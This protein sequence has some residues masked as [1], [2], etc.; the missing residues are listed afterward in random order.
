M[1]RVLILRPDGIGDFIIFSGV[2]EEYSKL[3]GDYEIHLICHP[4]VRELA[5]TIPFIGKIICI[6]TEKVFTKRH[7]FYTLSSVMKSLVYRYEKA[8][9]P[10]Y[11]PNSES[12]F[13]MRVARSEEKVAYNGD[14]SNYNGSIAE[15]EKYYSYLVESQKGQKSEL[16][17][18]L[19]FINKLGG[20]GDLVCVKPKI[21][22]AE[23]DD[24]VFEKLSKKWNV[25]RKRYIAIFPGAGNKIK[26]WSAGKWVELISEMLNMGL[27]DN[28]VILGERNDWFIIERI[29]GSLNTVYRRKV[30]N[31]YNKTPLRILA[32]LIGNSRAL[33]ASDSGAI[34]IASALNVPNICIMGGGHFGRFYPYGDLTKNRAVYKKLDCFG[35]NWQCRYSEPKCIKEINVDDI[36]REIKSLVRC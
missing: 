32:K 18:N 16:E 6:A 26:C 23:G 29:I 35:C 31:L 8:I 11:S 10:V 36:L 7:P 2:L 19:E 34:H 12:D 20:K 21:W 33:I 3:Y 24:I 5:E 30:V 27:Q 28:V 9:Y 25:K 4:K 1:K 15:R 17:R 13:L 22:F 14:Y